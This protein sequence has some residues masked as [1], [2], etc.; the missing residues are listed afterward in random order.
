MRKL[1]FIFLTSSQILQAQFFEN[2]TLNDKIKFVN[3]LHANRQT[4]DAYYFLHYINSGVS[5]DTLLFKEARYLLELKR[6]L[7]ADSVL[8]LISSMQN[9]S[10]SMI[11]KVKLMQNH[12]EILKGSIEKL[13]PPSCGGNSLKKDLWRI[14]L[15]ASTLLNKKKDEFD[16]IFNSSKC[17]DPIL[18]LLEFNLYILQQERLKHHKKNGFIAGLFSALL[19]G[20]GKI[21]AGKPH[22]A[23]HSFLPVALNAAQSAEG[24][25]YRKFKSPHFYVFGSIATVFYASNIVGSARA[26]KRYNAEFEEKIRSDVEF[27]LSKLVRYY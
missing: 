21:Y 7:N 16:V 11:C 26:C 3:Y 23:L 6:E 22:E 1:L 4:D 9:I 10:D 25:Y 27:E 5:S 8:K 2:I 20:S 12:V 24:Y 17:S 13:N 19:P 18:S 14:Q 15:L